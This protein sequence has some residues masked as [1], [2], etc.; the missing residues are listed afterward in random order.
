[1]SLWK[2]GHT[3][4]RGA[5]TPPNM[6]TTCSLAALTTSPMPVRSAPQSRVDRKVFGVLYAAAQHYYV[7]VPGTVEG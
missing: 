3:T 7:R 6:S 1:M 5:A 2:S 4:W